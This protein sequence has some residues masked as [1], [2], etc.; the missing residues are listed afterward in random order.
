M[1]F[2]FYFYIKEK[3]NALYQ[4]VT[5]ISMKLTTTLIL[6]TSVTFAQTDS[7]RGRQFQLKGKLINE[8]SLPP[9][10]G[11]IAFATVIEFEIIEFSDSDYKSN[12]VGVIFTCPEFYKDNFFQVGATYIMTVADE[13]QADFGWAILNESKLEKY[14]LN[15]K[16]WVVKAAK[17]Q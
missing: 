11:T 1:P 12:T 13:N 2:L 5:S 6:L 17:G 10:C 8:I 7:I 15:K 14:K 9:H 4:N 3:S 16:L